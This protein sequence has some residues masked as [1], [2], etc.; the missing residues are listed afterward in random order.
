MTFYP[1]RRLPVAIV[2][3]AFL[4]LL[5]PAFAAPLWIERQF[6]PDAELVDPV[7]AESDE[8]SLV[9]VDHSIWG[10]FLQTYLVDSDDGVTR[11][12]YGAVSAADRAGLKN[13]LAQLEAV[14]APSLAPP[15]QLAFWINLYNAATVALVL[16]NYP[17]ESIRDIDDPWNTPLVTVNGVALTLSQIESGVIRPVFNDSRIHYAVNCASVG[18]PNL[19]AAPYTGAALAQMLDAAAR[20]YVNH[21]RGVRLDDGDIIASKIYGWYREDF[22]DTKTEVLDHIRLYAS[23]GLL[24]RLEGARKIND[25]QYDWSL[26]DAAPPGI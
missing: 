14:D 20:A 15:E 12:R 18:C 13:Y 5:A 10:G 22:G 1:H 4:T 8:S 11:L 25:Y 17:T 6:I 3:I 21:P 2:L 7:F 16:D 9:V 24:R 19:A 23:P 26:N